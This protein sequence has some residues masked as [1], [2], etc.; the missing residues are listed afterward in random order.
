MA[1]GMGAIFFG[2]VGYAQWAGYWQTNIPGSVYFEHI[3]RASE[4]NHP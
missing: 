3:P 4:F 1:A 2:L